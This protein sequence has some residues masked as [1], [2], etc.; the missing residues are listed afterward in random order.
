L[1]TALRLQADALAPLSGKDVADLCASFQEAAADS[2]DDRTRSALRI[3]GEALGAPPNALVVAGGVAANKAIRQRLTALAQ[4][5]GIPF[6]APPPK[7]CTDNAAMIAWAG[8]ERLA[9]GT[10]PPADLPAR[11]RWPLDELSTSAVGA[12]K[13]GARA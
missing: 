13:R 1:K 9:A 3:F 7:L 12:G 10:V 6:V 2:V 8:A 5:T 4:A 11:A